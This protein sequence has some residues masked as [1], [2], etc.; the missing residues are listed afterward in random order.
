MT[1]NGSKQS[2]TQFSL[3]ALTLLFGR[4]YGLLKKEQGCSPFHLVTLRFDS[5]DTS[6]KCI[7]P[8]CSQCCVH[9]SASS[10]VCVFICLCVHF[11]AC[12]FVYV[13]ILLHVHL[14]VCSFCCMF[15]LLC[16]YFAAMFI[17]LCVQSGR[18]MTNM[19][20]F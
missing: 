13:F 1:I 16:V 4:K 15:I 8:D 14:S 19:V 12:S 11:S 2:F 7:K 5:N 9:F 3:K 20:L 10:F 6:K 17:L 18:L